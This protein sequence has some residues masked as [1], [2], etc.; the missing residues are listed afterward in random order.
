MCLKTAERKCE[1]TELQ[2][3]TKVQDNFFGYYVWIMWENILSFW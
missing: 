1:C 3:T 2:A